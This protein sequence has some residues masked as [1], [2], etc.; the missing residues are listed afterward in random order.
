MGVW[1]RLKNLFRAEALDRVAKAENP[2]KQLR[3]IADQ[4]SNAIMEAEKKGEEIKS[5]RFSYQR[6]QNEFEIQNKISITDLKE[7]KAVRPSSITDSM[8]KLV[9]RRQA[10]IK[11]IEDQIQLT[12]AAS[13][14][15]DLSIVELYGRYQDILARI[16]SVKLDEEAAALGLDIS[17][18]GVVDI[19]SLDIRVNHAMR[20]LE[21]S[22]KPIGDNTDFSNEQIQAFLKSL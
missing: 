19:P 11:Q 13:A 18:L 7:R 15:V 12:E 14:E 4:Y 10:L 5:K 2:V 22:G 6:Q 20:S 3:S 8:V 1:V 9:L 16:E 21:I 17:G